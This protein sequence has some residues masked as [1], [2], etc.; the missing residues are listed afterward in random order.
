[1][2]VATTGASS[3]IGAATAA[4]LE[5]QGAEVIGSEIV[6]PEGGFDAML[7]IAG[8]P[9]REGLSEKESQANYFDLT[10]F[11][12]AM[13]SKLRKGA[14]IVHL[15]SCAGRAELPDEVTELVAV[16]AKPESD[17]LKGSDIP[18]DGGMN[19]LAM[20]DALD[21]NRGS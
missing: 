19:A 8:L 12:E 3:G 20:S 1:M 21:L 11:S 9:P 2:R 5:T 4:L 10:T 7:Y 15:A 6:E 18:I 17:W 13:L 16:L 14:S